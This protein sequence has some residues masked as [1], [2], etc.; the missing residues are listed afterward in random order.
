MLQRFCHFQAVL[1]VWSIYTQSAWSLFL[2]LGGRTA[3]QM[4]VT[5]KSWKRF[6]TKKTLERKYMN[7]FV[8][9]HKPLKLGK[10]GMFTIKRLT[11]LKFLIATIKG[12]VK[13]VM[14]FRTY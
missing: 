2:E 8:K 9:G 10:P 5:H 7:K 12:T 3:K 11:M 14:T 6:P 13:T 1:F 4:E